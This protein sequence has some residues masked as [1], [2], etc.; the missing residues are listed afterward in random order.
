MNGLT[1]DQINVIYRLWSVIAFGP[2][3]A[4]LSKL[5]R[6]YDSA[7]DIY[8]AVT[9][10][11]AQQDF[12]A[13]VIKKA[14][15]TPLSAAERVYD[16]CLKRGIGIVTIDDILY[17]ERLKR[18][19]DPPAVLFYRGDISGLNDRLNI[20]IVGAR[21]P[22]EYS[23]RV[24]AGMV[25]VLARLGFDIISGFATGIDICS[26]KAAVDNGGRTFAVL[27]AGID[28]NYPKENFYMRDMIIDNGALI[29]E[30]LPEATPYPANFPQRNR[31]LSGIAMSTAVIEAGS[32][33][34]S[35]NTATHAAEQGKTVFV[36]PPCD[37]FDKIY[38]GNVKLMREGAVPLMGIS[39]IIG[40]YCSG[41]QH[42]I[43]ESD[44]LLQS[45]D[46]LKKYSDSK[47]REEERKSG[48][49]K[50][51]TDSRPEAPVKA[52]KQESETLSGSDIASLAQDDIQLKIL[53]AMNG[54]TPMRADDI[55]EGSGEDIGSVL[56]A[57]TELEI[58]GTVTAENGCY[59]L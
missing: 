50:K 15:E 35:L 10:D 43:N 42:T 48:K 14:E 13:S 18:I 3:T 44:S 5:C 16:H 56:A 1:A 8:N 23:L 26:H 46:K 33:S 36:V 6:E 22:S 17:P 52:V 30:Y 9:Q 20:S 38:G 27:G 55:A 2:G 39:D 49:N 34:G 40:E 37:L 54:G 31:I 4:A 51:K 24:T 11:G 7:E 29:T 59:S 47:A 45:L 57:L 41:M 21:K 32:K 19:D 25:R 58:M 53:T 12:S 28:H